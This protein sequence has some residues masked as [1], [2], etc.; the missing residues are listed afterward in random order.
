MCYDCYEDV[1]SKEGY[2]PHCKK[3]YPFKKSS[4]DEYR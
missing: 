2:C 3:D 4:K 1:R